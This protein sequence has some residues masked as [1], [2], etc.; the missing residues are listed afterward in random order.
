[1]AVVKIPKESS[2]KLKFSC[3]LD[4]KGNA[5][6]KSKSLANIKNTAADE[7]IY[8]VGKEIAGLCKHTL[9]EVAR[10]DNSVISE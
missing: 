9:M 5:I 8:A 1:M 3:G 7:N 6:T 10:V 2:L 4:E